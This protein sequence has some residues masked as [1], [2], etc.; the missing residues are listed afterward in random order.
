MNNKDTVYQ[1]WEIMQYLKVVHSVLTL[2][3]GCTPQTPVT[4]VMQG[5]DDRRIAKADY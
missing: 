5:S 3:A 4:A 2:R 1:R